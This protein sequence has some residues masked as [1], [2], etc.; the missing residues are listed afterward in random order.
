M[1]RTAIYYSLSHQA[2]T[3]W[4]AVLIKHYALKKGFSSFRSSSYSFKVR[5]DDMSFFSKTKSLTENGGRNTDRQREKVIITYHRQR[6]VFPPVE[7]KQLLLGLP[8]R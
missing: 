2:C 7:L 3:T 5:V 8:P 4:D 1:N 6:K